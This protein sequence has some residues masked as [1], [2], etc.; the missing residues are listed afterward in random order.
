MKAALFKKLI[1]IFPLLILVSWR[2]LHAQPTETQ[3]K[4]I[5]LSLE[6]VTRLA[7]E[8]SL[9][10]QMAKFDAY[11][12]RTSLERAQSLFDTFLNARG[13]FSRNKKMQPSVLLGSDEKEHGFSVG[14][15]KKLPTGT[16][17]TLDAMGTK[18]RSSSTFLTLNPYNEAEAGITLNQALG[19]NF[20][21]LADRASIKITKLDIENSDFSSLDDME[22]SLADVQKAY[23]DFVLKETRLVIAGEMFKSA[24]TLYKIY[25]DKFE[26]GL[27]EESELLAMEALV[28]K[29]YSEVI[30]AELEKETAKNNLLFLMN[31][32]SFEEELIPKDNL[33]TEAQTVN[34]YEEVE[35]AVC[36]RRDYKRKQNELKSKKIEIV[37]NK[38]S[39]WPEIDLGAS[40]S[41]NHLHAD[42]SSAWEGL[43]K[44][45]NDEFLVELRFKVP[46][47]NR[48]ARSDLAKTNLEKEKL[49]LGLKK[50]ERLI[51]KEVH[52]AVN[53]VNITQ[54]QVSLY[55][56]IVKMHEKKLDKEIER[57]NYGRSDADTLIRY[58][59][60]LLESRRILSNH[61]H[62]YRAS[63]IELER[64]K[65]SLLDRYWQEP[66]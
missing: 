28:S 23:W 4:V 10:I 9:D 15:E 29:R 31:S 55:E 18:S 19:R 21:G 63:L 44:N 54:N 43:G 37:V 36:N 2:G 32:G 48:S 47:E 45:A 33:T 35:E 3:E 38:N 22:K 65:N 8:N 53:L 60:D 5:E 26:R 51:L 13:Y 52:D 20:F 27:T 1:F 24:E 62:Q 64:V 41:R 50:I 25:Q 66:L 34:L 11:I 59:E 30:I 46:L 6:D 16:T 61:W 12:K 17:I 56:S 42:R 14:L 58:E 57:L 7:L 39:L 40:L 49:L